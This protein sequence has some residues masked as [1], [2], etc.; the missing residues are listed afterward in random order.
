MCGYTGSVGRCGGTERERG[1]L[2]HAEPPA[3]AGGIDRRLT[4][5]A[6]DPEGHVIASVGFTCVAAE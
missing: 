6:R 1:A 5:E 4:V 2:A 3:I